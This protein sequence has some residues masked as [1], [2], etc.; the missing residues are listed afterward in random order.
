MKTKQVYVCQECGA[1][2]PKWSGKCSECFAWNSLVEEI[3]ESS[4]NRKSFSTEKAVPIQLANLK[5]EQHTRLSSGFSELDRLLGGGIVPGS[6]VLI[7]GEPG[8]GKSTL[9]LQVSWALAGKKH[10]VLYVSGEESV[11][12]IKDRSLRLGISVDDLFVLS[13]VKLEMIVECI[14]ETKPSFVIIDSIQIM[15]REDI[16]SAPGSVSQVRE[17]SNTLM[18]VAKSLDVS[19]FVVG[20]VNKEGSLAGP[21]VLEHIV[22]TVLYFEGDRQHLYRIVRS[23]KNRFGSTHEMAI[24]E[25]R[26]VGLLE[27]T[28]PS[29][30][31]LSDNEEKIP[32]SVVVPCMEG[33][34]PLLVEVQALLSDSH[35]FGHPRRVSTLIDHNRVSLLIAI[36]EKRL[37]VSLAQQDVFIHLVGG[38][39]INE[40]AA[41]LGVMLAMMSSFRNLFVSSRLAVFGEV[42]L[43]GEIRNVAYAERRILESERLGFEKCI[44]PAKS[45]EAY[46]GKSMEVIGVKTV[47]EAIEEALEL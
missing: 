38:I 26:D 6:F 8:I 7:G 14:K 19:I 41:D 42:G 11:S 21:K 30:L 44:V 37:G 18:H 22:D 16:S 36:F 1:Q 35:Q 10:H 9:L 40:P 47:A 34:R 43:G 2:S 24:F 13:E 17:C 4:K 27:V 33:T 25:M 20:H 28:N 32:G 5:K 31:F 3:I 23:V 45:A 39:K 15:Y 46:K 29:E 12:Q